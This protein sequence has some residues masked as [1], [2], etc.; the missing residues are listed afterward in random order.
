MNHTVHT[1]YRGWDI[2]IRCM[3]KPRAAEDA[4][5]PPTF[6]ASAHASLQEGMNVDDWVDPRLQ[7]IS[8]GN[9]RSTSHSHCAEM[10]LAEVKEL[11]DAL[12]K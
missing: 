4:D 2:T 11:I 5:Q 12:K 7:V 10:L 1:E 6:T 9:R 8:S 3:Q